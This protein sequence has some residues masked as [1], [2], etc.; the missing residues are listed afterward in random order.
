MDLG[1]EREEGQKSTMEGVEEAI[2]GDPQVSLGGRECWVVLGRR[3]LCTGW[4]CH[5][6]MYA[7]L[8][9]GANGVAD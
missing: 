7:V 4:R 6:F 3:G 1:K 2:F 8:C 9:C 5:L